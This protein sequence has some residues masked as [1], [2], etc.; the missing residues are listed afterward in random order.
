MTSAEGRRHAQCF[1]VKCRIMEIIAWPC[2]QLWKA[3]FPSVRHQE[4]KQ[5]IMSMAVSMLELCSGVSLMYH[6]WGLHLVLKAS[7]T[8]CRSLHHLY[9]HLLLRELCKTCLAKWLQRMHSW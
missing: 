4:L 7:H 9:S 5:I 8:V 1:R 6:T 3:Q 2:L